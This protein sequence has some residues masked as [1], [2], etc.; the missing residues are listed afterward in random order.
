MPQE[1]S[2]S[3][4]SATDAEMVCIASSDKTD[5]YTVLYVAAA[6]AK[7]VALQFALSLSDFRALDAGR[8]SGRRSTNIYYELGIMERGAYNES[9]RETAEYVNKI[10]K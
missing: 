3:V 6:N 4:V 8:N 2:Q 9:H 7:I 5:K 1:H 10:I